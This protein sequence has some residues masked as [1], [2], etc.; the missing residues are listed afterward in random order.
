MHVNGSAMTAPT[1]TIECR[2][3]DFDATGPIVA[4]IAPVMELSLE[5]LVAALLLAEVSTEALAVM[6]AAGVRQEITYA[7]AA[8]G[9]ND[10]HDTVEHE[11][12]RGTRHMD[13][14]E[15]RH[16]A[17][18][19]AKVAEAFGLPIAARSRVAC[20]SLDGR[21]TLVAA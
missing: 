13:A 6:D 20:R 12:A 21:R 5:D 9:I 1:L 18:C 2:A 4:R 11:R 14:S 7:L 3:D 17:L 19:Q 15:R 16:V 8:G 10:V